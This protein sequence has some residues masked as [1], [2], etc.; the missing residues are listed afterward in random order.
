LF[1]AIRKGLLESLGHGVTTIGE[2]AIRGT[3]EAPGW[4]PVIVQSVPADATVFLELI[5][6]GQDRIADGLSAAREHLSHV[7]TNWLLGLSPHAPYSTNIRLVAGAAELCAHRGAPL[8][9]HLAESQEELELLKSGAGPFRR[10]LEDLGAWP[11]DG[12]A[13]GSRPLDYLQI[14]SVA[15]RT[16]VVHG[17]YL[18]DDEIDFLGN[19]RDRFAVAYCPRTHDFFRHERYPLT[20]L[21]S[22]GVR[23]ALGTD[24]RASTPDLNLFAEMRF[25]AKMYPDV[26][27]EVIVRM[28]TLDAAWALSREHDVGSLSV[29][30]S[31]NLMVLAQPCENRDDPYRAILEAEFEL[32]GLIVR[33]ATEWKTPDLYLP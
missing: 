28:A 12:I 18:G 4:S 2:I 30:K 9:I 23:V 5:G 10:L 19:H 3:I 15:P 29:G 13:F 33:G 16:L 21:L 32:E 11:G 27:K 24:S 6:L 17:N 7:G 25:A 1:G 31:S 14:L 20:Q 22:A 8:A 26:P